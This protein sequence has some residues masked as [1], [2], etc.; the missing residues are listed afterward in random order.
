MG[1]D[2]RICISVCLKA[3]GSRGS[4]LGGLFLRG[5]L[6]PGF[7]GS[8]R[9]DPCRR[10]SGSPAPHR[11]PA[12]SSCPRPRAKGQVWG[13]AASSPSAWPQAGWEAGRPCPC[14]GEHQSASREQVPRPPGI[15]G[16]AFLSRVHLGGAPVLPS[17]QPG[18][19]GVTPVGQ[20]QM[21]PPEFSKP[22]GS[23]PA[24]AVRVQR[25]D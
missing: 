6:F 11:G 4:G 14:G 9:P 1:K 5:W 18:G 22:L 2:A 15:S 19:L 12:P 24:R 13:A 23:S 3:R 17:R 21:H 16:V 7:L 25:R 8:S 10:E 20:V